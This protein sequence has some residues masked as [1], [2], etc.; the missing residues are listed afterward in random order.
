MSY[1]VYVEKQYLKALWVSMPV[2]AAYIAWQFS[3]GAFSSFSDLLNGYGSYALSALFVLIIGIQLNF[4][5]MTISVD[6]QQMRWRFGVL[7]LPSWK[8]SLSDISAVEIVDLRWYEGYGIRVTSKGMLYRASGSQG[9]RIVQNNGK[10]FRLSSTD[11]QRLLN[12]L[13]PRLA[14]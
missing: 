1:P 4:G 13:Q 11:P 7:A 8:V 5:T 9:L 12:Y 14:K 10:S 3:V 6:E 2:V